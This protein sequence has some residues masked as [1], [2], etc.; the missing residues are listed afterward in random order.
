MKPR[1]LLLAG[2][3]SCEWVLGSSLRTERQTG[4]ALVTPSAV[5]INCPSTSVNRCTSS[6]TNKTKALVV[7]HLFWLF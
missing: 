2:E 6:D 3:Q 7:L 1:L 5:Q 4:C